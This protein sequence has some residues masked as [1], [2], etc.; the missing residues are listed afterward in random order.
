MF[1]LSLY[2]LNQQIK[3]KDGSL[4]LRDAI[5]EWIGSAS[6]KK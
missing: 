2:N 6:D 4:A 5:E 1:Y 3:R